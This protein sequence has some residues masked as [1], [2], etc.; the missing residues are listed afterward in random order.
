[1]TIRF[2]AASV[3]CALAM[4]SMQQ[5]AQAQALYRIKP[6]GYLGGCT[7]KVPTVVGLNN[8]DQVAGNACNASGDTH[9]FL[10]KDGTPMVD[11]GPTAVGSYSYAVAINDAGL[12]GG[13][14]ADYY[15]GAGDQF[16]FESY[17]DGSPPRLIP[18]RTDTLP[19]FPNAMNNAGQMTG[20]FG[21]SGSTAFLWSSDGTPDGTLVRDL[22]NLGGEQTYGRDINDSGV[23]A[24]ESQSGYNGRVFAVIWKNGS[25][26]Q[27]LGTLGGSWTI[28]YFIN[29]SGQVTGAGRLPGANRSHAFFWRNDGSPMQDLGSLGGP[30]SSPSAL[31]DA[32]QVAG[33]ADKKS[34]ATHAFAWLNDG[35]AMK[36]L[37]TLGGSSSSASDIN[38]YGQVTGSAALAGGASHAFLWRN[39]GTKIQDLNSLIDSAD[40]LKAHVTLTSGAFINDAGDIVA[41]GTDDRTGTK[42]LPYLLQGTVLTLAPR[43]LTFGNQPAMTTSAAKSVTVTNTSAKA[44]AITSVTL[45]GAN[46]NQFALSHD[47]GTSLAG[48]ATCTIKVSFHP[49]SKGA[50][51]AVL[52]VNGGGGGLRSVTLTGAGT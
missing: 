21:N 9:A 42:N 39:D 41:Y 17:G 38:F 20:A 10:W 23:V 8:R 45:A 3:L 24:G 50:K 51:S 40:P 30:N 34:G 6:L 22:G 11:L 49:T 28:A 33:V 27:K 2:T 52:N 25:G 19:I 12:V 31:N 36:D 47:C 46:A 5:S 4:F 18:N 37:G 26:P 29:E 32:G 15:D 7:T 48:H 35:T 16:A 1:M 13:G 43:S 44:V 14:M